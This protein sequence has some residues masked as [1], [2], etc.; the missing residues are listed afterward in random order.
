MLF[1]YPEKKIE[2]KIDRELTAKSKRKKL[3]DGFKGNKVVNEVLD[4]PT[5]LTL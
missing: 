4:K 3:F 2:S 5:I 1:D